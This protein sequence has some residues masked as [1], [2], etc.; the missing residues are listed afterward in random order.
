MRDA[1][2][3]LGEAFAR[4]ED[5]VEVVVRG[6]AGLERRDQDLLVVVGGDL[7]HRFD[8]HDAFGHVLEQFD[9]R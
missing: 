3:L 8:A 4:E 6:A 7:A 9:H 5:H 1:R 2:R